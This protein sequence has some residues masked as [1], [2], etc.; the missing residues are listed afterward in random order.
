MTRSARRDM[1]EASSRVWIMDGALLAAVRLLGAA[2]LCGHLAAAASAE[3][4]AL[5]PGP[6]H[7][8]ARVI[9]GETLLLDDG[10][11]VRL[12]GALAPKPDVLPAAADEG[13]PARDAMRALQGLVQDR[14]VTLRTEGRRRDRYGRLLAQAFVS[15]GGSELWL[16]EQLIVAGHARA[17]TLPGNTAC[18]DALLT[19][20]ESARTGRR[21]LWQRAS[22][23]VRSADEVDALLKQAGRFVV[24]EGR[25]AQ[26]TRAQTMTY[27]NFGA[28]WRRD[29]TASL[30]TA[31]VKRL[32]D[33]AARVDAL[34][35]Q[36]VRV[37][38]WIERRN[39]PMIVLGSLDEIEV[40][41]KAEV[42]SPR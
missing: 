6:S 13:S 41:D 27:V 35:G 17:Y 19:A 21:G 11:E 30:A 5:Q 24:V 7:A 36:R 10:Q 2:V 23:R 28:D 29:F 18:L 9:D 38:G 37:R 26:V 25:V 31:A 34:A 4:C 1:L 22:Y 14:A 42:A 39:G 8:V 16:Q 40:L 15:N 12:I 33:G 3:P 32:A 20:E